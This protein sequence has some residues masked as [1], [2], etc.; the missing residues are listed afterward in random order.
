MASIG[1]P[2]I[3]LGEFD[4]SI[5]QALNAEGISRRCLAVPDSHRGEPDLHA[6]GSLIKSLRACIPS[7]GLIDLKVTTRDSFRIQCLNDTDVE[8][9]Q[10]DCRSANGSHTCEGYFVT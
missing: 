2:A 3:V 7:G 8:F 10:Y 6:T 1:T 5:I 9:T 4:V